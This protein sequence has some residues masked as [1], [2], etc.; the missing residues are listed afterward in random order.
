MTVLLFTRIIDIT[1]HRY[2][3]YV[4][5]QIGDYHPSSAQHIEGLWSVRSVEN[6]TDDHVDQQDKCSHKE[7]HIH[8]N[9]TTMSE[10][11]ADLPSYSAATADPTSSAV[12]VNDD[13]DS[14]ADFTIGDLR[15]QILSN[16]SMFKPLFI[17]E[18][19]RGEYELE[20]VLGRSPS[21]KYFAM[22]VRD[23]VLQKRAEDMH[24]RK[25][26]LKGEQ[27]DGARRAYE[28]VLT[29]TADM[30][31]RMMRGDVPQI[32]KALPRDMMGWCAD[33]V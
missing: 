18:K 31:Y 6:P 14:Y 16:A 20:V 5:Q 26:I 25:I 15:A 28:V 10:P 32:R 29:R 22:L 27:C 9:L 7:M 13:S 17:T 4:Q 8:Q 30:V 19:T 21:G 1:F 23:N 3:A 2:I 24:H 11:T 33:N 12:P